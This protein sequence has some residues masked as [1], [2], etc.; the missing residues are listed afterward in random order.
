MSTAIVTGHFG[1][2]GS[3]VSESL[4]KAGYSVIGIDCDIRPKLFHDVSPLSHDDIRFRND[5]AGVSAWHNIDIRSTHDLIKLINN[6]SEKNDLKIVVHCAAQPSHDWAARDPIMDMEI[7]VKGTLS[8][9]EALRLIGSDAL[10]VHLST[11]KVYGDLPNFLPLME[12][13]FRYELIPSHVFYHGIDESMS[14]DQSKHSL[15]GCSKAAADLYVQEYSRY[16][17]LKALVLRAGCLTGGR[18]RGAKLHGFLNYLVKSAVRRDIYEVIGY[19]G[20]QVRDNLHASDIGSLVVMAARLIDD[21]N[22]FSFPLV[23]NLGGGRANS[24]SILESAILLHEKFGLDLLA[25]YTD[26][27]RSGDHQWYISDNKLLKQ[28]FGWE[29]TTTLCDIFEEILSF[30]QL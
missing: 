24:V 3:Y 1:L 29:P 15:F 12:D 10:L 22:K 13:E 18:H 20:K 23:A 4:A 19:K 7:N 17:G 11:N 28:T 8:V 9:C 16:F 5:L 27:P 21:G 6:I 26:L 2:V 14:I 25:K 30:G